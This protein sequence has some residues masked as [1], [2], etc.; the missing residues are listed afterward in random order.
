MTL[1]I[2]FQPKHLQGAHDIRLILAE[3][4]LNFDFSRDMYSILITGLVIY[5]TIRLFRFSIRL[6]VSLIRPIIFLLLI[7]VSKILKS[8]Y[9]AV[10]DNKFNKSYDFH[11]TDRIA[12]S[13]W[14]KNRRYIK[15]CNIQCIISNRRH[16]PK[17]LWYIK[18][19]L[20]AYNSFLCEEFLI[21]RPIIS[22]ISQNVS[23]FVF[24]ISH[25]YA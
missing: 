12:I 13:L 10:C 18:F 4:I 9:L 25:L 21:Q 5:L 19:H 6:M 22:S 7:L 14:D 23:N 2:Y 20:H 8:S 16:I 11:S 17:H 1:N 3:F 15:S 24:D